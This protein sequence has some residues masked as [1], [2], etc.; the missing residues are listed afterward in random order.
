MAAM[1][2]AAARGLM[3]EVARE[4]GAGVI[5]WRGAGLGGS[6]VDLLVLPGMEAR[7][8]ATLARAG[9]RPALGDDGHLMWSDPN[10]PDVV[11][12]VL[13]A[14]GWPAYYPSVEGLR[15]RVTEGGELPPVASASDQLLI[16]AAEAVAGR[17]LAK[18]LRRARP[19]VE[20]ADGRES[21]DGV[22]RA[23]GLEPLADLVADPDRLQ[24]RERKGRLPYAAAIATALRSRAARRALRARVAGRLARDRRR[25]T[26]VLVTISGMDGAGKSTFTEAITE[27]LR[28]AGHPAH[29]EIVRIGRHTATLDRIAGPVKRVLRREGSIAD[30]LAAGDAG[31]GAD[32][33]EPDLEPRRGVAWA[34]ATVVAVQNALYCRRVARGRRRESI[35]ADRWLADHLID[36][37]FR[38]GRHRLADRI[39]RA[40]VP[41]PDLAFLLQIDAATSAARKPGDQVPLVLARMEE[42]YP[43]LAAEFG[44]IALDGTAPKE[45]VEA[46]MLALVDSLLLG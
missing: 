28:A 30:H 24:R 13:T 1:D 34:W 26:G 2:E 4:V 37:E 25:G 33:R 31:E 3:V 29:D 8:N 22:A 41:R 14:A 21:L 6:D 43:I 39:L 15:S 40:T 7:L 12:D 44:L 45:E 23:E 27:H 38:Y 18:V 32:D 9:L 35:V 10:G 20:A 5:L 36:F 46:V 42:R 17:P 11:V 16:V 19:L